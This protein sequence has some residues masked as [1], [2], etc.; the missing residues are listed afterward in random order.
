MYFDY[1]KVFKI[2]QGENYKNV[3]ICLYIFGF[4]LNFI[5]VNVI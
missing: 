5:C 1:Y 2:F 4:E 3:I